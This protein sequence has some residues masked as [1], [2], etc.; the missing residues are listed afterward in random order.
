MTKPLNKVTLSLPPEVD[1]QEAELLVY[2]ALFGK[3]TISSGKAS[4]YLGITRVAFLEKAAAHGV[5]MFSDD[6]NTIE[7]VL[8]I[9]P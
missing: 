4:E 9:E 2:L 1:A 8:D 7:Q 6:A 5:N 3:G